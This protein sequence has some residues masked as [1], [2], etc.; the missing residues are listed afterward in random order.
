[1]IIGEHDR[2]RL[3]RREIRDGHRLHGT[4]RASAGGGDGAQRHAGSV[5]VLRRP[6]DRS[7]HGYRSVR[8][9]HSR[10][11]GRWAISPPEGERARRTIQHAVASRHRKRR[12]DRVES[13][14]SPRA[15]PNTRASTTSRSPSDRAGRPA[16]PDPPATVIITRTGIRRSDTLRD[17]RHRERTQPRR[18][19]SRARPGAGRAG[20]AAEPGTDPRSTVGRR[21]RPAGHGRFRPPRGSFYSRG[22]IS[23]SPCSRA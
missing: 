11:A 3:S 15:A 14:D 16:R 8:A 20:D 6:R 19:R 21:D 2:D 4:H 13:T 22:G 9:T 17:P 23:S 12:A 10:P 5:S 7:P 1:M 18:Q